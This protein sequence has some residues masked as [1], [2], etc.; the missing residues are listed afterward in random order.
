M[1]QKIGPAV[2]VAAVVVLAV[3]MYGVYKVA[4]QPQSPEPSASSAPAYTRQGASAPAAVNPSAES[5]S[6]VNATA[7]SAGPPGKPDYSS[8][9]RKGGQYQKTIQTQADDKP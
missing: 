7:P 8:T 5:S 1:K 6:T 9:Y 4:F 2:I 3:L